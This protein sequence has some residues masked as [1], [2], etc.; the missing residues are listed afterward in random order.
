MS[1]RLV[2]RRL[3]ESKHVIDWI[4]HHRGRMAHHSLQQASTV[5]VIEIS[6]GPGVIIIHCMILVNMFTFIKYLVRLLMFLA[7]SHWPKKHVGLYIDDP[8]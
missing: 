5:Y 7:L 2:C 6:V 1:L 3:E 8:D 4:C